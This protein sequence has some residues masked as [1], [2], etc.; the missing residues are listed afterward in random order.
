MFY[1]L[2]YWLLDLRYYVTPTYNSLNCVT[3]YMYKIQYIILHYCMKYFL[4][5]HLIRQ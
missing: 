3:I 4:S 5:C 2:Q 1:V